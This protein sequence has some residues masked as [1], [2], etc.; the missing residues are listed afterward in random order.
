MIRFQGDLYYKLEQDTLG[1]FARELSQKCF[2]NWSE[3]VPVPANRAR[4]DGRATYPANL[5]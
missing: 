5:N 1:T 2:N 4:E 3:I